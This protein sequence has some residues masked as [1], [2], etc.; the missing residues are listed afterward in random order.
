MTDQAPPPAEPRDEATTR[1]LTELS[2][3]LRTPLAA[4]VG[5]ADAM[6]GQ[7]FGPLSE[8]YVEHAALIH[9]A[10]RHMLGL[11]GDLA[12]LA[13]SG[14]GRLDIPRETFDAARLISDAVSLMSGQARAGD[15]HLH[16]AFP[17]G[18]LLVVAAR[19]QLR[20]IV[21]NLV[22]NALKF[23]SAG[24]SV[25]V[26]A[27]AAD[28]DLLLTVADTGVGIAAGD[29]ER[30]S[31]PHEQAGPAEHGPMGAGL[32]LSLVRAFCEAHGGA[33]VIESRLGAGTTVTVRLPVLAEAR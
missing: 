29:L 33:M 24:G 14:A 18:P 16:N 4:I 15:V 25:I 2:H 7:A 22:A 6:R 23:T 27:R 11:V 28:D 10:G 1:F 12:G 31:A 30:L 20:Q 32:G 9:D 19:R 17:P 21:L 3:E 26:T 5:F 13:E 8:T